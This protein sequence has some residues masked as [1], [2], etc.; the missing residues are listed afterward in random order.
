MYPWSNN[1]ADLKQISDYRK[2]VLGKGRYD[3]LYM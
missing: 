1:I 2:C 3:K